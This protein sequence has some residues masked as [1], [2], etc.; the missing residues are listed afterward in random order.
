M[1]GLVKEVASLAN[2]WATAFACRRINSTLEFVKEMENNSRHAP[3]V[4]PNSVTSVVREWNASLVILESI[5]NLTWSNCI[6]VI[7]FRAWY[8]LK[9]SPI[10]TEYMWLNWCTLANTKVSE[11]SRIRLVLMNLM[12]LH[13]LL[14]KLLLIRLVLMNL[15]LLHILLNKLLLN[16]ITKVCFLK[17]KTYIQYN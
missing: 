1:L 15:M 6:S 13:I 11:S 2:V 16:D 3:I 5:S 7:H 4:F 9:A 14:N 17:K 12:L 10:S 8:N